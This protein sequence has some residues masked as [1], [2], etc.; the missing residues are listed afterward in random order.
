MFEL[1]LPIETSDLNIMINTTH[2]SE[3]TAVLGIGISHLSVIDAYQWLYRLYIP[4]GMIVDEGYDIE[5]VNEFVETVCGLWQLRVL[6]NLGEAYYNTLRRVL[7]EESELESFTILQFARAVCN[8]IP[9]VPAAME[10]DYIFSQATPLI[11][12]TYNLYHPDSLVYPEETRSTDE[13]IGLVILSVYQMLAAMVYIISEKL[14]L[15]EQDVD[16]VRSQFLKE[17]LMKI[18]TALEASKDM[19]IGPL[20]MLVDKINVTLKH[21]KVKQTKTRQKKL[22][23]RLV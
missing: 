22:G 6:A 7:L 15:I 16:S 21:H 5:P 10:A 13:A 4:F 20:T 8:A 2:P 9:S 1:K 11:N 12:G 23:L 3:Y 18:A 14:P 17:T 19:P